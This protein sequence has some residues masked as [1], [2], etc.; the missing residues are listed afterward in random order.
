MLRV[1]LPIKLTDMKTIVTVVV[2][3]LMAVFVAEA[4]NIRRMER[5][6]KNNAL[7]HEQWCDM[8]CM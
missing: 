7:S 2:I 1:N 6:V 3:A 5:G 4:K 8:L